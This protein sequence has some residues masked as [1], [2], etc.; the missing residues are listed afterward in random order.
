MQLKD[1]LNPAVNRSTG[2]TMFTLRKKEM[3]R[4]GIQNSEQLLQMRIKPNLFL[5][6]K[7]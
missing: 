6:K 1:I 2:Q 5:P 3:V 7:R 4:F